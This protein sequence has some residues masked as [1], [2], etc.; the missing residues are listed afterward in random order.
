MLLSG[1][2][3]GARKELDARLAVARVPDLV[4]ADV[5]LK[6]S[7]K[8]FAGAQAGAEEILR[9]NPVDI[10]ALHFLLDSYGAQNKDTE[11]ERRL[12]T[13]ASQQPKSAP[14][15]QL[16]GEWLMRHGNEDRARAAFLTAKSADPKY[17]NPYISLAS[18]DSSQNRADSARQNLAAV[19]SADAKN[20][21]A[22]MMLADLEMKAGNT[23][24]AIEQLRVLVD[25]DDKN[26]MALNN[27]AYLLAKTDPDGALKYAQR[28]DEIAPQNAAIEDT[29]GWIYYRKGLYSNALTHL[30]IAVAKDSTPRR[31][32][33]LGM[34]HVKLGDQASGRQIV[35]AALKSDPG[36]A[37]TESDW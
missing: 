1:D 15:Q 26:A 19:L 3:A 4:L 34:A 24:A 11:A 6:L 13:I 28:A 27:L 32:F 31:Q 23:A 36:L 37:A 17:P 2:E 12:L 35:A 33:H 20:L 25:S 8:D 14:I 29:L 18:L 30:K 10:R 21:P 7:H 16:L 9:Q 22:R 5:Y